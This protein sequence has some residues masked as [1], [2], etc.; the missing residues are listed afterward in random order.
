MRLETL[1]HNIEGTITPLSERKVSELQENNASNYDFPFEVKES[2]VQVGNSRVKTGFWP[3][4]RTDLESPLVIGG[5]YKK[6]SVLSHAELIHAFESALE[7][8]GHK[9][10]R[11]I[12]MLRNGGRM[13]VTY[14]LP[15]V[16]MQGPNGENYNPVFILKNGLDGKWKLS[17]HWRVERLICLNGVT[18]NVDE[19]ILS[20]KHS[21]NLDL[22]KVVNLLRDGLE[23]S[24]DSLE[25]LKP[26]IDIE[27]DNQKAFNILSNMA[28]V[29][30]YGAWNKKTGLYIFDAWQ[31]PTSDETPIGDNLY[32]LLQSG[33]RVFRDLDTINADSTETV[34]N[35]FCQVLNLAA[36]PKISQFAAGAL[37]KILAKP[38]E[39]DALSYKSKR[40]KTI[41][42]ESVEIE[43]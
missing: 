16:V 19:M 25:A 7:K 29:T 6:T 40:E 26:M 1:G 3:V 8:E 10:E 5:Y 34:R 21:A 28:S 32:R 33:T 27:I 20:K 42:V 24:S 30:K 41:D 35:R 17:G 12:T 39:K 11:N 23:K 9:F 22:S 38:S 13:V 4:V 15:D 14:R 18:A 37:D 36:N 31:N 43:A 2:F